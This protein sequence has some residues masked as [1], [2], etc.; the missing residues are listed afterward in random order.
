M[1]NGATLTDPGW[2]SRQ[3]VYALLIVLTA[4]IAAGR[5]LS[6][7]LVLEPSLHRPADEPG[8]LRAWPKVPP[9]AMPT[10]SSNDRSRWAT[11]RALVDGPGH[12]AVSPY[13]IGKRDPEL[14]TEKNKYGDTGILFEDGWG[15]VDR[16][17]HP[18]RQEF[19]SSKLPLLPTVL[20]GE[21]W[22]LRKLF[23]WTLEKQPW[24][25]VRTILFT[26]NWLPLVV[27]LWL[28]SRLIDRLGTTD[29]GRMFVMAAAC[30]GTFLTTFIISINN[31]IM[32]ACGVLFAVYACVGIWLDGRR[33]G[34]RFAVAGFFA[35]WAASNELPAASF[36]LVMFLLLLATAPQQ[37]FLW[38][39]PAALVPISA[40]LLTNYLAVGSFVPAQMRFG[41]EWYLYE[42]SHWLKIQHTP[43][44]I[45]AAA[46]PLWLY[47][48]HL[49]FGHHGIFSLSPIFLLTAASLCWPDRER[50]ERARFRNGTVLFA[51]LLSVVVFA[52]Y[53]WKSNNYGGWTSGP[54]WFFWLIPLW[55]LAMIPA[56][57]RLS[58]CRWGR[59]FA[60]VL[61]TFSALSAAYPAWNPW[62][63]PWIYNLLEHRGWIDY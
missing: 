20:A 58:R 16:V 41:S 21:Y 44:G 48:F 4:G 49:T 26:V 28:F 22:L 32:A 24:E 3:S 5:I 38:F 53:L 29:W 37:T 1:T 25:V 2:A 34:W 59:G 43:T 11:I 60:Y 9:K 31:H 8:K 33:D 35:A 45:D 51:F 63:H 6:T 54:R 13:A 15:S 12:E 10:F 40:F 46:D 23:G 39:V 62:R 17:L 30:L 61:L 14:V 52:F 7:Q 55:L 56:A 36:C 57:D 42:G 47:T 50:E 18:E 27:Y 19:Y